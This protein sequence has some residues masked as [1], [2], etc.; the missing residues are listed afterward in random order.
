MGDVLEQ[1]AAEA[2][3]GVAAA[4]GERIDEESAAWF[5]ARLAE[6]GQTQSGLSRLMKN[7]GD[8]RE[9]KAIL[10][11][12]QRMAPGRARVSGEMRVLLHFLA[13]S[14]AKRDRQAATETAA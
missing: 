3:A 6:V 10:R 7:C 13:K 1:A 9:R 5:R 8:D 2:E 14:R 4:A 12:I 11:S